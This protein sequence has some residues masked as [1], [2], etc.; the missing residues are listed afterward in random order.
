MSGYDSISHANK[1]YLI[2]P[3][4]N[5]SYYWDVVLQFTEAV[6][7]GPD[8]QNYL[9]VLVSTDYNGDIYSASFD[10]LYV[11]N[12]ATGNSWDFITTEQIDL[13]MYS[14]YPSVT[15]LFSYESTENASSTWE[16]R[17]FSLYA[18]YN[19]LDDY[20]NIALGLIGTAYYY[21]NEAANGN[22]NWDQ[23]WTDAVNM[24]GPST[25]EIYGDT[26]VWHY[27][28][29]TMF[30]LPSDYLGMFKFVE[31]ENNTPIWNN[32]NFGYQEVDEIYGTG[33]S[34]LEFTD[35]T[36][37]AVNTEGAEV[38]FDLTF[39][40]DQSNGYDYRILQIDL[41]ESE[42]YDPIFYVDENGVTIKCDYCI[43][44]DTGTVNNILYEAVDRPMLEQRIADGA[45]LSTLNTSLVFDMSYLF[46]YANID[47]DISTWDVSNVVNMEN[48]FE[49][50]VF[51]GQD[52]SYWNVGN[53][54]SMALMF[55]LSNFNSNISNWDVSRV[56]TM[57]GMFRESVF[58]QDI[59][60]WNVSNVNEMHTLF[61]Y[62]E[63]NQ[64]IGN[65]DVTNVG[66]MLGMFWDSPFDQ[67]IS[68][69]NVSNVY[70]MGWMFGLSNFNQPIGNWDVSNVGDMYGMF[71]ATPF[72]QDISNW[73][74]GSVYN[75]EWTFEQSAFNQPIGNWNVSNVGS[76]YG[77]F[78]NSQF[79]QDIS[80]WDVSAV[81]NMEMMFANS[82]FDQPIDQ[83]N[84]GNVNTMA[85]MFQRSMFNQP[86]GN[87]NV[88]SVYNMSGMFANNPNFNQDLSNWNVGNV[89]LMDN[90]FDSTSFNYDISRW[91][92]S[93]VYSMNYMFVLLCI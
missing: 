1:D 59:S 58:N 89:G 88:G 52:L 6:N 45:D 93:N 20:T 86:I 76:M 92:V 69:W 3:T 25:P 91:N 7:Y 37:F 46:S 10:T 79:N 44:G 51:N 55:Y 19:Y 56:Y 49:G 60:N 63:F 28:N 17:D 85:Y 39:T 53:V 54:Q 2:S 84:V 64:P 13:S 81:Y 36:A 80:G 77:M 32:Y 29:V 47:A 66:S 43:P 35:P 21:G 16:I 48:M 11:Q 30:G 41:D 70:D 42:N 68:N 65:W 87:W 4:F 71:Y 31:S 90:M 22:A 34:F 27:E 75:M 57:R 26:Y 61:A 18:N 82:A 73:N 62:S 67:D 5:L 38:L 50:A 83:W 40:I 24:L 12:R 33:V 9:Q 14:G 23:C 15:V 8:F 72:D 78:Y 74:V